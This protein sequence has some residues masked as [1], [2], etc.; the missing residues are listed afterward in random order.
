MIKSFRIN[1]QGWDFRLFAYW[2]NFRGNLAA[3]I[4]KNF[5]IK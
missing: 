3:L 1:N 5:P 2:Y 4:R